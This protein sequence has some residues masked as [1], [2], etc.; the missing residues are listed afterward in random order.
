MLEGSSSDIFLQHL[1]SVMSGFNIV[2]NTSCFQKVQKFNLLSGSYV[3][4]LLHCCD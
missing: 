3:V 4:I 1:T 2:C